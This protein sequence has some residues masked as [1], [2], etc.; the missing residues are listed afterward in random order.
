MRFAGVG[1]HEC[2][3][4][5]L[6][7]DGGEMTNSVRSAFWGGDERGYVDFPAHEQWYATAFAGSAKTFSRHTASKL[8]KTHGG[9]SEVR[10][11]DLFAV[12][13]KSCQSLC[14]GR[15]PRFS[16]ARQQCQHGAQRRF[17]LTRDLS[18]AENQQCLFMS[19]KEG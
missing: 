19:R 15:S 5:I 14:F 1:S 9:R 11:E 16:D 4:E 13:K 12:G 10:N 7:A 3:L 17:R 18:L 2:V 8:S 6:F